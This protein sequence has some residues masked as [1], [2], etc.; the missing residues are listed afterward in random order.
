MRLKTNLVI[1]VAFAAL[2][3]FVYFYEIKGGEERKAEAERAKQLADFD[4][5]E[6]R[7]VSIANRDSTIVL[8]RVGDS[9]HVVQPISTR[10]DGAAVKRLL[11]NL[12]ETTIES[13]IRDSADVAAHP[14]L[15][16]EYGL[17]SPRLK[18]L[19]ELHEGDADTLSFGDDDPMERFAYAQ[20]RSENLEIFTVRAWRFDNLNM[21]VFDL[22]ERQVLPFDKE[23]VQE[24]RLRPAGTQSVDLVRIED[25]AWEIRTPLPLAADGSTV[26]AMLSRLKNGKARKFV[27]EEPDEADLEE[28]GLT[29][30]PATLEVVLFV[31]DERAEKRLSVGGTA[32]GGGFYARDA[33]RGPVFL[34]DSTL[35][36]QLRKPLSELRDRRPMRIADRD[37]VRRVD[38]F[39]DGVE[40]AAAERDS[41][42]GWVLESPPGRRAR[43]WRWNSLLTDID[44]VE[45]SEF[46]L[47]WKAGEGGELSFFGLVSPKMRVLI[48]SED[49]SQIDVLLGDETAGGAY[50]T[51]AGVPSVY[52]VELEVVENLDLTLDDLTQ[53]EPEAASDDVGEADAG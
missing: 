1:S 43:A 10:A 28:Y 47:D 3:A 40:L 36:N 9:W 50:L 16:A 53:P 45:V 35:V 52:R 33:S 44:A 41:A 20:R 6:A 34:A 26:N 48:S 39:Q 42:G 38:V 7:R 11:R 29:T 2:L 24:I 4:D 27:A 37:A 5:H 21:G 22:R 23:E 49:G 31:G 14:E 13:V 15:L 32:E 25:D 17:A 46:V 19:L 18:V 30:P 12:R 51:R 8:E